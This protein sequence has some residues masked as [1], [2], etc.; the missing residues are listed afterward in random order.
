MVISEKLLKMEKNEI[1][2]NRGL[3]LGHVIKL[4]VS[5]DLYG[6]IVSRVF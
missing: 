3:E 4:V 5:F 2:Y 6:C 1:S